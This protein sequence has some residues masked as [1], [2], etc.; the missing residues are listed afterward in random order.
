MSSPLSGVQRRAG[1]LGDGPG[2]SKS[3]ITKI[4]M[5]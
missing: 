4:K 1:E 5:L 3:E 2:H